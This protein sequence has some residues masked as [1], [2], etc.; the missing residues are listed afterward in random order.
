VVLGEIGVNH[1]DMA[2]LTTLG[3]GKLAES[4][5]KRIADHLAEC[6]TCR[7][8]LDNPADDG[9]LALIRLLFTRRSINNK[10]VAC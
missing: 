8:F 2:Q 7:K 10:P 9:L 1:P 4:E 5:A 6:E 3:H